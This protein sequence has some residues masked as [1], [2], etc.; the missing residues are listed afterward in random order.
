MTIYPATEEEV[1]SSAIGGRLR[2]ASM[3]MLRL[4]ELPSM[5]ASSTLHLWQKACDE[6]ISEHA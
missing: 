2:L 4:A 6:S 5:P 3:V 1:R